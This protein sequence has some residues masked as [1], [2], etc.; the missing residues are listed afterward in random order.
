MKISKIL[1]LGYNLK[2][3]VHS[4]T[5]NSYYTKLVATEKGHKATALLVEKWLNANPREVVCFIKKKKKQY[6]KVYI[7]LNREHDKDKWVQVHVCHS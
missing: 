1:N 3:V 4:P 6:H 2:C 7:I 5:I